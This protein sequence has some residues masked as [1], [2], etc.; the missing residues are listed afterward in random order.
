MKKQM[1]RQILDNQNISSPVAAYLLEQARL[2]DH[3]KGHVLLKNGEICQRVWFLVKG[4]AKSR[5]F[6]QS[7]KQLIT[8]FW[9]ENSIILAKES[10]NERTAGK[11]DLVLLEDSTLLSLDY[12]QE[13]VLQSQ[14]PESQRFTRRLHLMDERQNQLRAHLLTLPAAQAYAMFCAEF[15]CN[16]FLLQD[17]AAYLN[18]TPQSISRVRRYK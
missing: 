14:Y 6:D 17:I 1:I 13:K 7:G 4:L 18:R 15:D 2:E 12:Q 3:R 10:F 9:Q 8:R 16:R 5:Y 11:Q